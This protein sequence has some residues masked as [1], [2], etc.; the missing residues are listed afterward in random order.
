MTSPEP[1]PPV[2]AP[3]PAP[4]ADAALA[5]LL[6][7]PKARLWY[8]RT[9]LWL[10]IVG[11]LLAAG[12]TWWWMANRAANAAPVYTTQA[13]GQPMQQAQALAQDIIDRALAN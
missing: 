9:G 4:S 6:D 11:L 1:L 13:L 5:A 8:L 2:S 12:G 10:G 3:T 7:E